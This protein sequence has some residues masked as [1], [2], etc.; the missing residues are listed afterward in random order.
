MTSRSAFFFFLSR[1][2][3]RE[4]DGFGFRRVGWVW[5]LEPLKLDMGFV[6]FHVVRVGDL[7]WAHRAYVA[8]RRAG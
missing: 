5:V 7:D 2:F 3:R 8:P 1:F 4:R 6:A